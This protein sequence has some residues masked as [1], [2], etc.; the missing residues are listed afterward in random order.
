MHLVENSP[1]TVIYAAPQ[2]I[3]VRPAAVVGPFPFARTTLGTPQQAIVERVA[4]RVVQSWGTR[5]PI[6]RV[7]LAGHSDRHEPSPVLLGR[8]RVRAVRH[9]LLAAIERHSPGRSRQVAV[10]MQSLGAKHPVADSSTPHGQQRNRRVL[11]YLS[12]ATS[13]QPPQ[14][15]RPAPAARFPA[16]V[17]QAAIASRQRWQV[18]ASV[19]L[20][21]W[22]LESGFG[23]HMPS[24]SNN[25][26]GIKARANQPSVEATTVEFVHGQRVVVRAR[27]RKFA[28]LA[29][30]FD[31]HG[32]LLATNKVYRPAM[33]V[34]NDPDAFADALTGVYATA[35]NYGSVLKSMMKRYNLYQYDRP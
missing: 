34:R 12:A 20:A 32:R 6:R 22:A 16:E 26:F 7:R 31:L 25:P 13:R 21:Q 5:R 19:T 1:G 27:F 28:S 35:P 9:A 14:P 2:R 3:A 8:R 29:E 11:I 24:G 17:I 15:R 23:A 18:P 4:R 10:V 33:Q 30:A